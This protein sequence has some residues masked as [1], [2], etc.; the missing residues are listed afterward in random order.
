MLH[1]PMKTC[2]RC[3]EEKLVTEYHKHP[4]LQYHPRCKVCRAATHREYYLANPDKFKAYKARARGETLEE[5]AARIQK[6]RDEAPINRKHAQWR[7]HIRRTLGVTP[8]QYNAM[9]AAQHGACA[10]CGATEPGGKRARFSIDHCHTTG[11]IR[12]LLCTTCNAGL[13]YFKD[14]TSR[15]Q[16][17]V[18]Y[19]EGHK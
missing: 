1:I 18:A 3:G 17:A 2:K 19:L 15:L 4:K 13:G 8:E 7:C 6:R 9:L 14:D 12:G 10:I 11:K 5:R 16:S